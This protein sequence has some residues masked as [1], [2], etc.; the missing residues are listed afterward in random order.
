MRG[1]AQHALCPQDFVEGTLL[2]TA[3][4]EACG[5][6]QP[7]SCLR[8]LSVTVQGASARLRSTGDT[9]WGAKR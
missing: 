4:Q 6:R 9:H 1:G 7:L 2:I 3:E 8:V 5:G